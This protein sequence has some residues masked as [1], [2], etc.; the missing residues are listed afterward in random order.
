MEAYIYSLFNNPLLG[1]D[2]MLDSIIL[3]LNC[4]IF[5][6]DLVR[7]S[8]AG[9]KWDHYGCDEPSENGFYIQLHR[10]C[11]ISSDDLTCCLDL[12]LQ[13]GLMLNMQTSEGAWEGLYV[14]AEAVKRHDASKSVNGEGFHEPLNILY[15]INI[16]IREPACHASCLVFS[17]LIN[18]N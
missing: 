7:V 5:P 1:T 3:I 6:S 13:F 11:L 18:L 12:T 9:N 4:R 16:T 15:H 10:T 17:W 14:W 2:D 8:G